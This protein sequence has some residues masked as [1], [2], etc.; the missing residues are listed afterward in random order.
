MSSA[1]TSLPRTGPKSDA[2]VSM[3]FV[4]E[5]NLSDDERKALA[6]LGK[7]GTVVVRERT[8][9]VVNAGLLRPAEVARAVDARLPF[10]FGLYSHFPPMWRALDARP[11]RGSDHPERTRED[12]CIY[13]SSHRD[14]LYTPAF[15][16]KVVSML[17]TEAKWR[18]V[19]GHDPQ[20]K[21]ST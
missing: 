7:T 10:R 17:D 13:D 3:A 1:Y 6:V 8:R 18:K 2:D 15:V 4:R 14:Y 11:P 9:R 21:T 19:F 5:E 12:Y 20:R 16:D